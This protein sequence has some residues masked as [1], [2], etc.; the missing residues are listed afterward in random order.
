MSICPE[1][2]YI[3]LMRVDILKDYIEISLE[4]FWTPVVGVL[5]HFGSPPAPVFAFSGQYIATSLAN[6]Y[7]SVKK[8]ENKNGWGLGCRTGEEN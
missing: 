5:E 1:S 3:I 7:T 2:N 4:H 6:Y 8:R